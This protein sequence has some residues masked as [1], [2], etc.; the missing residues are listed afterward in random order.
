MCYFIGYHLINN[1]S[2]KETKLPVKKKNMSAIKKTRQS[3]KRHDKNIAVKSN[4][5]TAAKKVV[6][7]AAE[8]NAEGSA[9]TLKDAVKAYAKAASKG[10]I[11][12]KTASRKISRLAKLTNKALK[13]ESA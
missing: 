11:H 13:S 8:K 10:I 4:L 2:L 6:K 1:H 3:E 7:A 12:R 9:S 5:K